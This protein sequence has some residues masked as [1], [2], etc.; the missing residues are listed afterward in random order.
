MPK[1][2]LNTINFYLIV[3]EIFVKYYNQVILREYDNFCIIRHLQVF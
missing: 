3:I 1:K 2:Q